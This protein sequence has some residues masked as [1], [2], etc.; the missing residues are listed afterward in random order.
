MSGWHLAQL[1]VATLRRPMDHPDTAEFADGLDPINAIAEASPGFVWRLQDETGNATGFAR[2]GDPLRILNLSVWESVDDLR[3]FMFDTDHIGF[4][5]RRRDWFEKPTEAH[6][7]LW[8]VPV[9]HQPTIAEAEERLL[10]LQ[11]DGPSRHGFTFS[12]VV[13]P[14]AP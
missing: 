6:V 4:M 5:R 8:W 2:G 3:S 11:T 14:P 1:N 7:V 9:G 12:S 13:A 10:R